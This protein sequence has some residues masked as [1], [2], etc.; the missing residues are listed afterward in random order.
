MRFDLHVYLPE[1]PSPPG[2]LNSPHPHF[3][4]SLDLQVAVF[5]ILD[6]PNPHT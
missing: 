5:Q 3:W 6:H 2:V 1:I 4:V